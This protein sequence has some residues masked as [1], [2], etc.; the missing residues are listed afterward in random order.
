M[1]N[2]DDIPTPPGKFTGI[3]DPLRDANDALN[4]LLYPTVPLCQCR[5]HAV[6]VGEG[7]WITTFFRV[8]DLEVDTWN[9][10]VDVLICLGTTYLL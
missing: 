9:A 1:R 3:V 8:V 7:R 5:L 4:Y 2:H 6:D 10:T